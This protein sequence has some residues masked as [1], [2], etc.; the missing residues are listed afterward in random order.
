MRGDKLDCRRTRAP[1]AD[2]PT[3]HLIPRV[4]GPSSPLADA[5]CPPKLR[6]GGSQSLT[7]PAVVQWPERLNVDQEVGGSTPP[8]GTNL[9][10]GFRSLRP[11]R[12]PFSGRS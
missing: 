9:K 6:Q 1:L 4:R 12:A 7:I 2:Q 8:P 3:C 11:E 10:T 5:G